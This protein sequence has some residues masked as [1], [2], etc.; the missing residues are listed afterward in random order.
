MR[1]KTATRDD[2]RNTFAM[3]GAQIQGK[4]EQQEDAWAVE[5]L[6]DG[7]VL[8]L[9][10]D[11]LG[12]HPHGERASAEAVKEFCRVFLEQHASGKGGGKQWMQK[13]VVEADRHLHSL[14]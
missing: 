14:Q 12:G 4:R 10:A 11:G 5:P 6:A 8:A 2:D 7:S 3:L 1:S 9:V 13:A